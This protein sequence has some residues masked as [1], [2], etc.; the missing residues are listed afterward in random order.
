MD[1]I[2]FNLE[3]EYEA[4][5]MSLTGGSLLNLSELSQVV[6]VGGRDPLSIARHVASPSTV[7]NMAEDKKAS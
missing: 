5:R 7:R 4:K 1:H 6:G 3:K 2:C